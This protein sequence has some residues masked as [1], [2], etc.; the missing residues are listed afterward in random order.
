MTS[1]INLICATTGCNA[2]I[3]ISFDQFEKDDFVLNKNE[4]KLVFS[5]SSHR[6][7]ETIFCVACKATH[8]VGTE[9]ELENS[10]YLPMLHN[11]VE[12]RPL[13]DDEPA[14]VEQVTIVNVSLSKVMRV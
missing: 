13:L 12:I 2:L 8:Q 14:T 10:A 3:D 4:S 11:L 6:T 9:F 1:W 5:K 7:P